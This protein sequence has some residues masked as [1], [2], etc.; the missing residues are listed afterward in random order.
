MALVVVSVTQGQEGKKLISPA[1]TLKGTSFFL[2]LMT[3][4]HFSILVYVA[5]E[6]YS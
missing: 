3:T 2:G 5:L 6:V 4:P 1:N